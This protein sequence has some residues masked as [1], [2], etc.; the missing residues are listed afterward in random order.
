LN[1]KNLTS[2][3][4]DKDTKTEKHKI[5]F[6]ENQWIFL[7]LLG[8]ILIFALVTPPGSFFSF[9]NL[10]NITLDASTIL[11]IG[12]GMTLL[13]IAKGIDLSTG[14]MAIFSAIA[15]ATIMVQLAGTPDEVAQ[16]QYPHLGI[17]L[18]AGIIVGIAMGA[19]WGAV[20]G[21]LVVK[22]KVPP[23]IATLGTMGIALGL[24][25]VWTGGINV[26][27]VP[28]PFQSEF[29]LGKMA[30][31]IPWPVVVA[32]VIAAFFWILLA[33]TK[34]GLHTYAI[35]ANVEAA[36]RV[37]INTER[38][39]CIL[40]TIVGALCGVVGILDVARFNTASVAS[41]TNTPLS[42]ISAIIIGGTS[43]HGGR[44]RISGTIIGALIQAVLL[45]GFIV[46]GVTPFWQNVA[47]GVVLLVAVQIDQIRRRSN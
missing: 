40:Y 31:L 5:Q 13:L 41:H 30:G 8:L 29:G 24:A 11:I 26:Q 28:L 20:N 19:L 6:F 16:F 9:R 17:A 32:I 25:Q 22:S 4:L 37:G 27:H 42:V 10:Q 44:G 34:F 45:N 15:A 2:E 46:M 21:L 33:Y 18:A 1:T 3:I 12:S 43:M 14:S 7:I 35:G 39:I 36:R 38:H 23:F 47:V